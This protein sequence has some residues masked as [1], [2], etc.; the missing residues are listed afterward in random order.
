MSSFLT[1][2][3]KWFL[4]T[5]H[6]LPLPGSPRWGGDT[7]AVVRHAVRDAVAYA[8]GGA[9]AL[10]IENFHDVPFTCGAVTPEVVA[11]MARVAAAIR[12]AVALPMGFNVLR[13]DARAG[14]GLCAACGGAFLRVNVHSGVMLTDQGLIEGN[15]YETLRTRSRLCPAAMVLADVQVKHAVP[16]GGCPIEQAARDTLE[17]GLADALIVSGT[18]TGVATDLEDVRRVRA[19]CPGA[20][21]LLGSGVTVQNVGPFLPFVNGAIVGSS[22]KKDGKLMNPVD[23]RRVAA[24]AKALQREIRNPELPAKL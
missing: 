24:L 20:R 23:V 21:L 13:N 1:G 19:A 11:S 6:L 16:L 14:V 22:L 8:R 9:D 5:V 10:V 7:D 2:D 15:A 12:D 4:G 3:R 17:R 18:G